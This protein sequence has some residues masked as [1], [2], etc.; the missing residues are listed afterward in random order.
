MRG[1]L[2]NQGHY[3][4]FE[5]TKG[6]QILNLNDEQWYA[7]V[8]GQQGDLLVHSDSDHEKKKTLQEGEFYLANFKDDPEFRDMPHLF[9]QDGK[10]YSEF[11]LPNGF[12]TK[13][14]HQ[15]KLIRSDEK[16]SK[17]KVKKHVEGKGDVGT[18]KQYQ[19]KAEHL[20]SK[21]KHELYEEAKKQDVKGRSKMDKEELIQHLK[22]E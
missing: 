19:G 7:V 15:K 5:T 12:P 13:S 20:R 9:L 1:K 3:E 16:I 17:D 10:Q 14:D 4:L 6:H 18:E 8:E 21:S 2:E 11:I 22:E